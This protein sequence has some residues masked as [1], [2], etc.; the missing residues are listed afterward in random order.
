MNKIL[1]IIIAVLFIT[2][3]L[4]VAND[5]SQYR[6]TAEFEELE[7][8]NSGISVYFK[9]FRLGKVS[10]V[11]PSPNFTKTNVDMILRA[12]NL[13][14]PEN[15]T[16]KV[17]VKDEHEYIELIYPKEPTDKRLRRHSLIKG[18]KTITWSSFLVNN[19]DSGD[20]QEFR[21]NLNILV[22]NAGNTL[23]AITDLIIM[24]TDILNDL[25]PSIKA[26]GENLQIATKNL[27]EV[28]TNLNQATNNGKLDNTF[29]NLEETS[30]NLNSATNYITGI[31]T[32]FDK[33]TIS[34]L[35]CFLKNANVIAININ[36]I[37]KGLK[38]TLS[39]R[40]GTM[41]V[42]FGKPIS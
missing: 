11:Y 41:K 2:A 37:I 34:L 21:D 33:E 3:L 35:N 18:E 26:S 10:R 1:V 24:G 14:L 20:M 6:I 5:F 19:S 42:F 13:N 17:K 12:R 25:R 29:N 15:I 36:D 39:K 8:I 32:R 22:V 23:M 30:R 28:T 16:A 9:G 40:F 7:P 31:S 27:A 38:D 4:F